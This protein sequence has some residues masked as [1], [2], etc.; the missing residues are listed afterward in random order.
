MGYWQVIE[1]QSAAETRVAQAVNTWR[2]A[3]INADVKALAPLLAEAL[4]Y[5]HSGGKIETKAQL[6]ESIGSGKSDF[7][8]MDL[9]E[10]TIQVV[11]KTALVRH[12]LAGETKD[13]GTPGSI[14]L[15]V[16]QVWQKQGGKWRLLARQ[17]AKR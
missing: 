4:S 12:Y 13:N 5:G 15:L 16:L 9:T 8:T 1:A 2:T 3:M 11:G 7:I 17:A 6:L 10:Q 14:K